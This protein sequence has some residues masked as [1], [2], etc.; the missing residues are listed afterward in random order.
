MDEVL[1]AVDD[2]AALESIPATGAERYLEHD[3]FI[4]DR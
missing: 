4:S 2:D 3:K 1:L